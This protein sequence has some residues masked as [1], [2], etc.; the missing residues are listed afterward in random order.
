MQGARGHLPFSRSR[1]N[2][3]QFR[4]RHFDH[5]AQGSQIS[6]EAKLKPRAGFLPTIGT[7]RPSDSCG[8]I[9]NNATNLHN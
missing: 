9:G 1:P 7:R 3:D 5:L 8:M 2:Q 6:V 4:P